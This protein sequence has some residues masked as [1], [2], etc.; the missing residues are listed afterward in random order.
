[1]V[2]RMKVERKL[3][4]DPRRPKRPM[5]GFGYFLRDNRAAALNSPMMKFYQQAM[6]FK[7]AG[8]M[9]RKSTPEVRNK[10]I[11]LA[12]QSKEKYNLEAKNY[13]APT[14]EQW[15]HIVNNWPKRYR[16]NYNF[17]VKDLFGNIW[18]ANHSA[19]THRDRFGAVSRM[20]AKHWRKLS[21]KEKESYNER[22]AQDRHRY[23]REVNSLWAS[24]A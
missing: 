4:K 2:S 9:W 17:F 11:Q 12:N 10:A 6:V 24:I 18:K 1:M 5:N 13:K 15:Q 3:P 20:V 14:A 23:Q 7:V 8:K 21:E 16:V 22:Y 19:G